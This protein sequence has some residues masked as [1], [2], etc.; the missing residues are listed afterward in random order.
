MSRQRSF[1]ALFREMG[2]GPRPRHRFF[3][4]CEKIFAKAIDRGVEKVYK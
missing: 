1:F 3:S 4:T 2:H